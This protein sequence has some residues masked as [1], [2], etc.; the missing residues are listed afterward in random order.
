VRIAAYVAQDADLLAALEEEDIHTAVASMIFHTPM[1][2]IEKA[3]RRNAK[4]EVFTLIFGGGR[5]R[6]YGQAREMGSPISIEEATEI[7]HAFFNRFQGLRAM[8]NIAVAKARNN[9]VNVVKMP[10]GLRRVLVGT[11]NRPTVILNS[12]IQ[13]FAAAGLKQGILEAGKQGLMEYVGAQ[14]HD[15]LVGWV[16]DKYAVDY[17]Q[18]LSAAMVKGMNLY[19]PTGVKAEAKIAD[20]WK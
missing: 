13:G 5:A 8:K 3:Q 19:M 11:Q 1:G 10:S 16:E 20:T 15:E 17:G 2:N 6:V 18:A 14:V 4:A 9:K 12:T 7:Y